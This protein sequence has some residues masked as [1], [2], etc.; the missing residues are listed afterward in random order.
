MTIDELRS[1]RRICAELDEV[2]AQLAEYEVTDCV[3]SAACFPYSVRSVPVSGLPSGGRV[4]SLLERRAELRARKGRVERFIHSI[5][6]WQTR[7]MFEMKFIE[8]KK[9]HQIA[10][11]LGGGMSA[12]CVRKRIYRQI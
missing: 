4:I 3:Q 11:E 8:G 1:Y 9:Y 10:R 7:R 12:D 2:E 5:P 6:D